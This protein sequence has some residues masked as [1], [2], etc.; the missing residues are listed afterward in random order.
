MDTK[1]KIDTLRKLMKDRGWDAAVISGGDPHSDEYVPERWQARKWLS[2]FTGSAGDI[3]VTYGHAG[4]WTD[5][6]YFI[7]ASKELEGS[8]IEIH[9]HAFPEQ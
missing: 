6:R 7:Q 8:G 4:L 9:K 2:G 1:V 3:V 5:G